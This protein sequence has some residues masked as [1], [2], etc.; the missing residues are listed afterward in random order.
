VLLGP[1]QETRVPWLQQRLQSIHEHRAEHIATSPPSERRAQLRLG[2]GQ[3]AV[4]YGGEKHAV[5][6]REPKKV[7]QWQEHQER[8]DT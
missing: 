5:T 4:V 8:D 3:D 6:P 2:I 1:R 7:Q